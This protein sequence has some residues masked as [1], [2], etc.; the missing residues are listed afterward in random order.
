M[1]NPFRQHRQ[2]LMRCIMRPCACALTYPHALSCTHGCAPKFLSL[3]SAHRLAALF[4]RVR[5]RRIQML[6]ERTLYETEQR[7]AGCCC[8]EQAA[9]ATMTVATVKAVY[10]DFWLLP[11]SLPPS[12][13]LPPSL[14]P[15]R[16]SQGRGVLAPACHLAISPKAVPGGNRRFREQN[17]RLS[18][19]GRSPALLARVGLAS[20][21]T[22][23]FRVCCSR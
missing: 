10:P 12:L 11:P 16:S 4:D 18:S 15:S 9:A 19:W 21:N 3:Q 1:S 2:G 22:R 13:R 6:P 7:S 17:Q 14:P 8:A 5:G 23:R 20:T